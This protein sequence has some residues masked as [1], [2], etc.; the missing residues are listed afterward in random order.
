MEKNRENTNI[1]NNY[2]IIIVL[3]VLSLAGICILGKGIT[4][5]V[6]SESC[7]FGE[8]CREENKCVVEM[9]SIITGMEDYNNYN[10]TEMVKNRKIIENASTIMIG[11][12]IL[13]VSL[14]GSMA[15]HYHKHFRK[16]FK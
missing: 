7:C 3:I 15:L 11:S 8:E 6:I 16:K 14:L 1:N 13:A 9:P 5:L 10:Q 12:F 2:K 4:G